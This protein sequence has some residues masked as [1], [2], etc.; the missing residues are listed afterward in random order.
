MN[1]AKE[2]GSREERAVKEALEGIG[3]TAIRTLTGGARSDGTDTYDLD[4]FARR[5]GEALKCECK[6]R[7]RY[8]LVYDD[9]GNRDMLTIRMDRKERIYI[10]PEEIALELLAALKDK[11]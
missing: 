2:K 5:H 7:Q 11:P 10:F 8:K 3:I 4:V 6:A 1:K 9:L